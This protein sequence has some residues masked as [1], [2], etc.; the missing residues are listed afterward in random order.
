MEMI[1]LRD[2]EI[3]VVKIVGVMEFLEREIE[4]KLDVMASTEKQIL[5][6]KFTLEHL[7]GKEANRKVCKSNLEDYKAEVNSLASKLDT[8]RQGLELFYGYTFKD[9]VLEKYEPLTEED[10]ELYELQKDWGVESGI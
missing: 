4:L 3:E 7:I 9:G 1:N 10:I 6:D 2:V 5:E 8:Q